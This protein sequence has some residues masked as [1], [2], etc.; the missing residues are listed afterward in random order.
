MILFYRFLLAILLAAYAAALSRAKQNSDGLTPL[1]GWLLGLGFFLLGP[2]T[3]LTLH[4]GYELPPSEGISEAFTKVNLANPLFLRPYLVVWLSMMFTCLAVFLAGGAAGSQLAPRQFIS[5]RKLERIILITMALSLVDWAVLVWLVGGV[6]EFLV[7]HWYLRSASLAENLGGTFTLYARVSLANQLLFT[8]AAALHTGLGLQQRKIKWPLTSLIFL[9]LLLEMVMS[10]NRIFIAFYLLALVASAWLYGRR[11]FIAALLVLSP[12]LVLAFS[13]W[14]A[15]RH[16]L[17]QIPDSFTSGI[18]EADT[19]DRALLSLMHATEGGAVMLLLHMVNDFGGKFDYL[20]GGT[21]ARL[22]TFWLP[23]SFYPSR[24]LDFTNQAAAYYLPGEPTS[25][26]ATALG[27]AYANFGPFSIFVLPLFTW[28][29]V[30]YT[31]SLSC[32]GT[33]RPLMS[34]VAF[35]ILIWFARCTFAE[36]VINLMAVALMIRGLRLEKDLCVVSAPGAAEPYPPPGGLASPAFP[37]IFD[38]ST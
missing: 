1:L 21:Y 25:L 5:C 33:G 31:A 14:G 4:G 27:E 18:V 16:D 9:F 22:L 29:V 28:G 6:A 19:G 13:A 34:A 32:S 20:Y 2:L 38:P 17:S 30:K 8:G 37:G 3:I 35:V 10:G 26:C 15:V 11:K 23:R 7:S 12:V 24:P 36:N